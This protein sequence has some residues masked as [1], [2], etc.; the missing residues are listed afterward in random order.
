MVARNLRGRLLE[1][2]MAEVP[3]IIK[4][5]ALYRRWVGVAV[6]AGL[7]TQAE[8]QGEVRQATAR[9]PGPLPMDPRPGPLPERARLHGDPDEVVVICA[10]LAEHKQDLVAGW[11]ELLNNPAGGSGAA[12]PC[13]G[14]PGRP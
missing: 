4:A 6:T 3:D 2:K 9:Q 14:G 7:N 8:G 10:A 5:M 11:W 1:A 13:R 12:F